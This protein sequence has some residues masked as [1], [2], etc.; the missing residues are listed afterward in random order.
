LANIDVTFIL[1]KEM[2]VDER[3]HG[4]DDLFYSVSAD[5]SKS[6]GLVFL[7]YNIIKES[8]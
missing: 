3:K 8:I 7:V 2:D 1:N 6:R 5:K 4:N